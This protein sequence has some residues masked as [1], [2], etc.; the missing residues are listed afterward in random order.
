MKGANEYCKLF[1]KAEQFGK[2]YILP[3]SHARGE[4]FRIYVLPKNE[5][6]IPNAG[7]NPPL[8]KEVVE[9]YGVIS[10]QRGWTEAYGW[11]HKGPWQED[12]EK[13]CDIKREELRQMENRCKLAH[14]ARQAEEAKSIN[15]TLADY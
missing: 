4:T 2:L 12:F 14:E 10:G 1:S 13:I 15:A 11:L 8:N 9:V 3:G 5:D 6:A 7:I